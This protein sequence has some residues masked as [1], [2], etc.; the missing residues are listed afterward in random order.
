MTVIFNLGGDQGGFFLGFLFL[1][2]GFLLI[3]AP[4]VSLFVYH[5][6]QHGLKIKALRVFLVSCGIVLG[7]I[8]ALLIYRTVLMDYTKKHNIQI[9]PNYDSSLLQNISFYEINPLLQIP[10]SFNLRSRMPSVLFQGILKSCGANAISNCLKFHQKGKKFQP[11]RL[12]IHYNARKIDG[13]DT[14]IDNSPSFGALLQSII[15]YNACDEWTVPYN[16]FNYSKKPPTVAYT[17]AKQNKN[18]VCTLIFNRDKIIAMKQN[19][20]QNRPVIFAC[21]LFQS[22]N[23]FNLDAKNLSTLLTGYI[24]MPDSQEKEIGS[25]YL[26]CCCYNDAKK[27]FIVQNSLGVLLGDYGYFYFPYDYV[28]FYSTNIFTVEYQP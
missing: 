10:S 7:V 9:N 25:H 23:N 14:K 22:Y 12:F 4:I 18:V 11:S 15:Q 3:F 28:F 13:I 19:I 24:S 2:I 26:I 17:K 21:K 8:G 6:R 16:T 1:V 5:R 27:Y 20:Y